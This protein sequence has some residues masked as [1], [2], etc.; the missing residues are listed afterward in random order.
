MEKV[1]PKIGLFIW[2]QGNRLDRV[3]DLDS[4]VKTVTKSKSIVRSEVLKDIWDPTFLDSLKENLNDG[5]IDRFLWV[6]RFSNIQQNRLEEAITALGLNPYLN[7]FCDLEDQG[8]CLE[9]I[10]SDV[11]NRKALMLVKASLAWVRLLKPL[12]P[13]ELPASNAVL[14]V[15]AGIAGL[16]T[17]VSLSEL[18][19]KVFLVEK[20]SGVG[21]KV[22][23]LEKFYPRL[24]DPHCGLE[25]AVDRLAGS[26]HIELLTCSTVSGIEGGPG[27]FTVQI[28]KQ[29]RFIEQD[30]CNGCGECMAA[31]P[32]T[33]NGTPHF[34]VKASPDTPGSKGIRAALQQH[35]KA[36]HPSMPLAFPS[37][38]VIERDSCPPDCKVC[39]DA[40]PTGAVALDQTTSNM[41][42][43]VGAVIVTTGW[44]PYP[45]SKLEEYGY[46]H[47]ENVVSNLEMERLLADGN[48]LSG[49]PGKFD[50]KTLKNVGFIQCVGSRDERHLK[51]CSSVCCSAT[52]KQVLSFKEKV[53]DAN[54]TVFYQHIRSTGFEEELYRKARQIG[55]VVFLRD[56]PA[57]VEAQKENG[58]LR[59][60]VLDP[61]L[62]KTINMDLDLLV[63][64][65]GMCPSEGTLNMMETFDLP[66]NEFEF[67]ESHHQCH[68]DEAQ[69]SG[70]F[71]GGCAREPMNVAQSIESSHCAAMKAM[72]FLQG[73]FR[74]DP[75]FPIVDKTK[76]DECKRCTEDCPYSAFEFDEKGIPFPNLAKCRQ[77]GNCM[78]VCPL[79]A[80]SL[81]HYTIAQMAAQVESINTG[82]MGGD[83]PVILA[84]LCE[85]D[86]Y[87]AA[88]AAIDKGMPVPPNVITMKVPC[89]GTVNNAIIADALSFGIDGV[90]IAGCKDG[91]CH[92]VRGNQLVEKRSGDLG[93]KLKNM[94]IEPERVF[95]V[96]IE[97]RDSKKYVQL[98]ESYI[99][100][101]KAMGPN[102]FRI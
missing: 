13:V 5:S 40:C 34:S 56:R 92:Y 93:D 26:D 30:R 102:P 22:A 95:S 44:D 76:C 89:A 23:Q 72:K 39:A 96:S 12:D 62:D 53:P 20:Q 42:I 84:F 101:L 99:K 31:C 35:R 81:Q 68:P 75:C 66:K 73:S 83:E 52:L 11:Q 16:Q 67:P 59:V 45:L 74:I 10:D 37:A 98:L 90:L 91:Q 50:L 43:Q 38:Y 4:L 8:I 57:S 49:L 65:G 25:F 97:V 77:C 85:N 14:I 71:V 58:Q 36:V 27:N 41:E 88:Q 33:L 48:G 70:V 87:K 82:F 9:G 18:G 19:K 55:D 3:I 100:N 15:G 47:Y 1:V 94:M 24:C 29:P 2:D 64:A 21:G 80:I 78:G 7:L 46:G 54:C 6:G 63:L 51:Y 17:A 69:R 79:A 86:A 32:L 60:S 28:E 61:L